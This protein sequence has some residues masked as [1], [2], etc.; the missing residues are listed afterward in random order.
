VLVETLVAEGALAHTLV[1]VLALLQT[2]VFLKKSNYLRNTTYLL[3]GFRTIHSPIRTVIFSVSN[4]WMRTYLDKHMH[5]AHCTVQYPDTIF[6][7][8]VP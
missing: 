3:C 6:K 1:E 5:L 7:V 8:L 4:R 2:Q